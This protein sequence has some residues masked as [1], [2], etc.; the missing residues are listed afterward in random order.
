MTRHPAGLTEEQVAQRVRRG[1]EAS[2]GDPA[3]PTLQLSDETY[4]LDPEGRWVVSTQ[5]T[6]YRNS[7][8]E[9]ETL[10]RQ[11][12]QGLLA[13]LL[14]LSLEEVC[15]DCDT[16]LCHDWRSMG[17]SAEEVRQFC[18]WRDAPMRFLS[19]QGDVVDSYD[20]ALKGHRT[21]CFLCFNGHCYM[22]R[23]VKRVLERDAWRTLYRGEA[24]QELPPIVEWKRFDPALPLE[25]GLFWCED[26]REARR[27]LMAA[28]E[29]PKV[30]LG[31]PSQ[32][33]GLR[34]RCGMRIRELSEEHE[35]L[36]RWCEGRWL[37]G[38]THE[39]FLKLLK[40]KREVPTAAQRQ[41]VLAV[42][43]G[44]CALC[45][46][47]V[48]QS[49]CELDHVV[50]VRQLFADSVQRLQALCVD[51]HSEKTLRESAQ[52]TSLE[53]RVCPGVMEAYVRSPKLPPLVFEAQ[54]S[55][56]EK[57]YVGVDVVRC[58]RNGL[59]N[60]PFPLPILC[61]ADG[62][63]HV[64]P[65]RLPDLG[66]VVP[67]HA[68][69]R[70]AAAAVCGPW[71]VPQSFHC[72]DAGDGRVPLGSHPADHLRGRGHA[73][74]GPGAHGR[75]VARGR[76]AHGQALGERDDRAMGAPRGR[77]LLRAQQQLPAGRPR[78][79]LHAKLLLRGGQRLGL[80][81]HTAPANQRNVLPHPR[82][83]AG[84]RA[85]H[86]GQ[87]PAAA[88]GAPTVRE[89]GQDG[90]RTAYCSRGCQRAGKRAWRR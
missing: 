47:T 62:V 5:S 48:T 42:Q 22:Y 51:C 70:A 33:S 81:V 59:A 19:S 15:A 65:G 26:L 30:T 44:L 36:R 11:R 69:G 57:P 31:S 67:R 9:V 63:E 2:L 1:V 27:D 37:A 78:R 79:R 12:M 35:L 45:G 82:R 49:A 3:G 72:R 84:L 7:R 88:G 13:E 34:L 25:P 21:V 89:A 68:P 8:T 40:A 17:V 23:C 46:C 52:P 16:M 74:A 87:G 43:Q 24:R 39:V 53:S 75:C 66:Y 29:S 86:G 6:H 28:G 50:P 55:H 71:L 41:E 32:Y 58:R 60:A 64:E 83:R 85:L 90:L 76:G 56:R 10:L 14:Q 4:Y 20:P 18:V 80:R 54:G 38:L 61:P 77:D 73:P